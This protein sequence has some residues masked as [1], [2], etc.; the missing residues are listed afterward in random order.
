MERSRKNPAKKKAGKDKVLEEVKS[1][2]NR[3]NKE[4]STDLATNK[5]EYMNCKAKV[6][7]G[8][9]KAVSEGEYSAQKSTHAELNALAAYIEQ[10]SDFSTIEKI[11]ITSP[12]CKSC[13]FV[14]ELLG[15]IDKVQT[16][17]K[18][19]KMHTSAWIWPNP[20]KDIGT[21]D[22][23]RWAELKG[24]FAG[25]GLSDQEI[26]EEIINVVQRQSSN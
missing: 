20:L 17:G 21:F 2:E 10:E 14:L 7:E 23:T 12:P 11:E 8:S 4:I 5:V 26:L 18:I 1:I 16:T 9:D 22:G 13:A 19:H 6:F 24:Y 15:A 3:C 25:S